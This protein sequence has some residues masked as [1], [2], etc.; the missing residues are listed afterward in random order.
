MIRHRRRVI[1]NTILLLLSLTGA[2]GVFN[3]AIHGPGKVTTWAYRIS[4]L[5]F[6]VLQWAFNN[7]IEASRVREAR[8]NDSL[9]SETGRLGREN[10]ELRKLLKA[11]GRASEGDR[12]DA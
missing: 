6:F 10:R 12:A 2:Y 11:G 4:I 8:E 1:L 3:Q 7:E 9:K 5:G